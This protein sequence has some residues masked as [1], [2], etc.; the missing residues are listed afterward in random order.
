MK[1]WF[2]DLWVGF[3]VTSEPI[4]LTKEAVIRFASEFDPQPFH[5]DEAA[6]A[7]TFFG[8]LV[9][10]GAHSYALTMRLG[11]NAGVFT[12]NAVA[13]LGVD[14]MRFHKPVLP[15]S[16]L[17]AKFT[18]KAL[19]GSTSKPD[20]GVVDWQADTFDD[21]GV[22]VFSAIIRNLVRRDR[23]RVGSQRN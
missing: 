17:R 5:M 9:A 15:D 2:D 20:L 8:Q 10:S 1:L 14:D 7:D 12:G 19:R 4:A 3:N 6:A 18:V 21:Q 16:N 11:V 22:R 13:G 23:T